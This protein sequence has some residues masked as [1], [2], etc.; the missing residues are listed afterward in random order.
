MLMFSGKAHAG[1]DVK[2]SRDRFT[3][4]NRA[5]NENRYQEALSLASDLVKLQ[6]DNEN[7]AYNSAGLYIDAGQGLKDINLINRGIKWFEAYARGLD[8]PKT[9]MEIGSLYNLAN[10]HAARQNL[11][12]SGRTAVDRSHDP[13]TIEQK[14]CYRRAAESSTQGD[15]DLAAKS[16]VNFGNLLRG[17]GRHVEA[18][19]QY[20]AALE[21][22]PRHG[23]ALVQSAY[24]FMMTGH[25]ARRRIRPHLIEIEDRLR[26]AL[27]SKTALIQIA[28]R[29]LLESAEK[30]LQEVEKG[31]QRYGG[32]RAVRE[33]VLRSELLGKHS[34]KPARGYASFWA[35]N[36]LFISANARLPRNRL[37]WMDEIGPVLPR[38]AE[39]PG[40]VLQRELAERLD[41][42]KTDYAVARFLF[43][44]GDESGRKLTRRRAAAAMPRPGSEDLPAVPIGLMKVAYRVA[45]D[46]LDKAAGYIN[47]LLGLGIKDERVYLRT[48]WYES[49]RIERPISRRATEALSRNPYVRGLF[50][51]SLDWRNAD[52]DDNLRRLRH[53][54]TH[55]YVPIHIEAGSD[56]AAG[57]ESLTPEKIRSY[58]MLLLRTARAAII[59]VVGATEME[60][61]HRLKARK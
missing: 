36:R 50:D 15:R 60:I 34:F 35:R 56:I 26:R 11:E 37:Y 16:L 49:E 22:I 45:A 7:I 42:M 28:G 29:G 51:L 40:G 55:R 13:D 6:P 33:W 12:S 46:I 54:L 5:M 24:S 47:S 21:L 9:R 52:L 10:G 31:L 43:T 17:L 20:E 44:T 32:A 38:G 59:H 4:I 30:D 27:M 14:K 19:D 57:G 2:K 61:P 23:A 53:A 48:I 39:W 25:L 1:R 41:E 3:R 18:L 58:A 8:R